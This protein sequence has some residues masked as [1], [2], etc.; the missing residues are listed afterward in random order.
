[1]RLLLGHQY[2][3]SCCDDGDDGYDDDDCYHHYYYYRYYHLVSVKY[4]K[5]D[6]KQKVV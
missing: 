6:Y 3:V 1:M 4:V 2:G 5:A